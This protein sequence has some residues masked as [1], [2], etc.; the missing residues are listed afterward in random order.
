MCE[1]QLLL[2]SRLQIS[3]YC[4]NITPVDASLSASLLQSSDTLA[5]L[6]LITALA[7]SGCMQDTLGGVQRCSS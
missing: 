1:G 5:P 6:E 3:S 4:E 7:K 2:I